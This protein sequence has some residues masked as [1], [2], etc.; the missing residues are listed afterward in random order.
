VRIGGSCDVGRGL[1]VT[2]AAGRAVVG[3]GA[4]PGS[5]GSV[6]MCQRKRFAGVRVQRAGRKTAGRTR[7]DPPP[8]EFRAEMSPDDTGNACAGQDQGADP[9]KDAAQ[10]PLAAGTGCHGRAADHLG[11]LCDRACIP[12]HIMLVAS[13]TIS[14]L[15]FFN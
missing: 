2:V 9:G 13:G 6:R 8:G 10:G 4:Q 11:G 15:R 7:S 3:I 1:G 5:D 14:D 12:C